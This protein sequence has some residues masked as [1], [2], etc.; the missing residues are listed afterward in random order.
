LVFNFSFNVSTVINGAAPPVIL[1]ANSTGSNAV[2][3]NDTNAGPVTLTLPTNYTTQQAYKLKSAS[4][5]IPAA[6]IGEDSIVNFN[7][8]RAFSGSNLYTGDIGVLAV[9]WSLI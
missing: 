5:A 8:S 1:A 2:V 3:T 6:N 4:L 7:I 9:Y